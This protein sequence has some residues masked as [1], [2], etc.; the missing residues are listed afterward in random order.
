M[1][2]M[3]QILVLI[4]V[5]LSNSC[6]PD[7]LPLYKDSSQSVHKRVNDLMKRMTFE[8]KVGQMCQWV[9]LEHMATTERVLTKEELRNN[10][11][12]SFYPG[13]TVEEVKQMVIDGMIGSFLHVLTPAESNYLQSIAQKSRLQIPLL[14]GIDAVHGNAQVRGATVYPTAIGQAA[15]FDTELVEK[16]SVETAVEMR[17]TGSQWNFSP[18]IEVARDPRWGRVGETFGEDPYLVSAMGKASITG[19]QGSLNN[20]D[21]NVIACAK[22]FIG[23]S[24]PVNG[25]NG[26]PADLSERTLREIFFP[27]FE[28]AVKSGALTFMM[29][30]NEVNGIPCHSNE[31]LMQE[32]LKKEWQFKGFIVSDWMDIEHLHDLHQTAINNKDAFCQAVNA[33]IDMHMHGPQFYEDILN[34]VKNKKISKKRVEEACRKILEIKFICGLFDNPYINENHADS[35]IFNEKHRGT[36]LEAARKSITLLTN[37]GILP[38]SGKKYHRIFVT[39]PNADSHTILGDWTQMQPENNVVTILE[40]LKE[41]APDINFTYYDVG[42]KIKEMTQDKVDKAAI[43]AKGADLSIIVVGEH[44]L[45]YN[46]DEK[47]CGE[48]CDRSDIE[49]PGL[50]QQLVEKIINQGVPTVVVLVNGRQ[51]GI[52]WIAENADALVEAWEPGSF[53]GKAV[54]EILFGLVNPSGKLPVTF[55]EHVGQI[56]MVYNYKPSMYFHPYVIGGSSPLFCFGYGLS[57]TMYQFSDLILSKETLSKGEELKVSVSVTNNGK[58]DGEEVVQIYIRDIYSSVTRP[59]KELKHFE[60]VRLSSGETKKVNISIPYES[61]GFYDKNMK[62][63]VE[64]GDFEI[65]VGSSSRD[66]DLIKKTVHV[67]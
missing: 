60:R 36:A 21:S 54:A 35:V 14:I 20:R 56:Q 26:A 32:V 18:N 9:G 13:I 64:P 57:Y 59:V 43:M 3:I 39:G 6:S 37:N 23:G 29:A 28:T 30:H 4:A 45:R 61:L 47:T 27:P 46:W 44:Q 25:T 40:G 2:R 52:K 11:A 22:H 5:L 19:Y 17:A 33:G 55:P 50:Q 49:L 65:F 48:D 31:W 38:L 10:S 67:Q 42:W 8:E 1:K 24:Q 62:W 53:G 16:I 66:E 15:T 12:R 7:N 63:I 51:S 34:L 41:V 58:M